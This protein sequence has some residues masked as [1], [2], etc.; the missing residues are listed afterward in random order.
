M[1]CPRSAI[2]KKFWSGTHRSGTNW[3]CIFA[4]FLACPSVYSACA[5]PSLY[6][7]SLHSSPTN[8]KQKKTECSSSMHFFS[9]H[10]SPTSQKLE[11]QSVL[12]LWISF[13]CTLSQPIRNRRKKT[14]CSGSLDF[15]S[16]HS[17]SHF[18]RKIKSF[19]WLYFACTFVPHLNNKIDED[20]SF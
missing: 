12:A 8:Q 13:P 7:F 6:F 3:H 9:L 17:C 2:S 14:E 4:L 20:H 11:K 19:F 18:A 5:L 1:L 15:F 16:L 10:S